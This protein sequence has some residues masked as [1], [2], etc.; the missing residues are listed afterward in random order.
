MDPTSPILSEEALQAISD[1]VSN[2][3]HDLGLNQNYLS[4]F[5]KEA[6]EQG[7]NYPAKGKDDDIVSIAAQIHT[8]SEG[9]AV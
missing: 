2:T 4:P 6:R 7:K 9:R 5:A 3:A 1:C 8:E